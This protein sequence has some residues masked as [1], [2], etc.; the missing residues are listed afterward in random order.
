V[1]FQGRQ[2]AAP[3]G[4]PGERL[5]SGAHPRGLPGHGTPSTASRS[6]VHS[7][8]SKRPCDLQRSAATGEG[9][10]GTLPP[11]G[12]PTHARASSGT[13]VRRLSP[14]TRRACDYGPLAPRP[15]ELAL[16]QEPCGITFQTLV[17]RE[18]RPQRASG[19]SGTAAYLR[20][21]SAIRRA[22]EGGCGVAGISGTGRAQRR[23]C[24]PCAPPG[25]RIG[26]GKAQPLFER[27]AAPTGGRNNAWQPSSPRGQSSRAA[28]V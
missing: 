6:A 24:L 20:E 28:S 7:P 21:R 2:T 18:E 8:A 10:G 23:R 22:P 1:A 27:V 15:G 9:C 13:R 5:P 14:G 4:R 11:R 26:E 16:T 25:G 17:R 12:P 3:R 19:R